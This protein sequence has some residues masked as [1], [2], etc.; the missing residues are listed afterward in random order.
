MTTDRSDSIVVTYTPRI[1]EQNPRR[2]VFEPR[3][4]GDW[5]RYEYEKRGGEWV[6]TGSEIVASV[7]V[8]TPD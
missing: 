4:G 8:E 5:T 3:S 2:I 7:A 1:E 6:K